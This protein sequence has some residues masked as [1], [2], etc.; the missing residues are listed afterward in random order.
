MVML[1]A[2]V[3][4]PADRMAH[5]GFVSAASPQS[6]PQIIAAF[7]QRL[8]ELGYVE[9][10]NLTIDSRWAEGQPDK[11]PALMAEVVA[12]NPDV[13]V[14]YGTRPALIAREATHTIP[15]VVAAMGDPV[16]T[17]LAASLAR[18]GGNL[19]GLSMG[20][21]DPVSGKW[22]ELL[23]EIVPQLSTV[24]VIMNPENPLER[25]LTTKLS[26]LATAQHLKV[27]PMDGRTP[28]A[29][30]RAFAHAAKRAQAIVV[31]GDPV[32][33]GFHRGRIVGLAAKHRLP[34][35]YAM[36]EYVDEGGLMAYGP[37]VIAMFRRAAD[38]VERI[39]KGANPADLPI[40]QP[41]RYVFVL[42]K[43]AADALRLA[44]PPSLEVRAD[45]IIK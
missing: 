12:R 34:A 38:Y 22:L 15:I 45:E 39:L 4:W 3:S 29:L 26:K 24:V 11:L 6:T 8:Q 37:D 31:T 32:I 7:W 27:K 42:N 28:D 44:I 10:R 20:Y 5:V 43:K 14:T 23:R 36:R 40:E 18:P 25:D 2:Q 41:T 19:T 35:M 13:I 1:T 9:G 16:A 30:D 33:M 21:G 17:G